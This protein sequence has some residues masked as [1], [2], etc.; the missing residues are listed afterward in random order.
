M[1]DKDITRPKISGSIEEYRRL[2]ELAKHGVSSNSRFDVDI[3]DDDELDDENFIEWAR[4][5][6]YAQELIFIDELSIKE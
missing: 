3:D 6:P 4:K 2:H 5:L 1:E